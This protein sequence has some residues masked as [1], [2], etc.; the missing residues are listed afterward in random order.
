[1]K[2][3][4]L[5]LTWN[6]QLLNPNGVF[7]GNIM[8]DIGI[9]GLVFGNRYS[10]P[11]NK[12][13]TTTNDGA[14]NIT[15]NNTPFFCLFST[16]NSICL[17]HISVSTSGERN[18]PKGITIWSG[19]IFLKIADN[20]GQCQEWHDD[21]SDVV[22]AFSRLPSCPPNQLIASFDLQQYILEDFTSLIT[23]DTGYHN[24]FMNDFH[25]KISVCYRLTK[26]VRLNINILL[27]ICSY[28]YI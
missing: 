1:M 24:M 3:D 17:V 11:Q 26:Y 16:Y 19:T 2:G 20:I 14:E 18:I 13:L 23:A 27:C 4:T 22:S 25:P 8:V 7:D 12:L 10:A 9:N 6:P 15:I 28:I 21:N 5:Q